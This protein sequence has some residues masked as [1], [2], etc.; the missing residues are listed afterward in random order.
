[1]A[2]LSTHLQLYKN[3]DEGDPALVRGDE[4]DVRVILKN[5]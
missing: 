3:P 2:S 1:M 4:K 5:K